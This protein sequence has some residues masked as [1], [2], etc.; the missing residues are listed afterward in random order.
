[1][2]RIT[3][4]NYERSRVKQYIYILSLC[5]WNTSTR[6]AIITLIR[7]LFQMH[8]KLPFKPQ[9]YCYITVH[10]FFFFLLRHFSEQREMI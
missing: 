5:Y 7:S 8:R 3:V 6:N 1:M 2:V 9:Y 4:A 10:Y